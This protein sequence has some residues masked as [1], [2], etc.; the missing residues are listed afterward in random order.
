MNIIILSGIIII[1]ISSI[2]VIPCFSRKQKKINIKTVKNIDIKKYMGVWFEIAR[3]PH[4][5]EKDLVGVTAAYFLKENGKISVL[6]QGYK[7]TLD[8]E[9]KIAK[10]KARIV[11]PD[12]LGH[13]QVTFFLCFWTDYLILEIDK[14]Y[15]YALVGS[16]SPNYLWILSRKP[17]LE[18]ST[19]NMLVKK[20]ESLGYD[21]SKLQKV[22]QK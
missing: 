18:E 3:F 13:L 14:D 10:G 16:S 21:I 22:L 8:G 6:N 1:I 15:Q 9:H 2:F 20:A 11:N 17:Q 19:Y 7:Y 5:F 4:K 12:N